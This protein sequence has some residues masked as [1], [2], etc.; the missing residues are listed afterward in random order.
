MATMREAL[1]GFYRQQQLPE[2]G[3]DGARLDW[4]TVFGLPVPIVNTDARMAVLPYHDMHHVLTGYGTDEQ[5]EALAGAWAIGAAGGPRIAR[6]YDLGT[7]GLGMLRWPGLTAAAFYRG[8]RGRQL[9]EHD[10]GELME[11]PVGAVAEL[12][13]TDLPPAR[14]TARDRLALA[15]ALALAGCV[16]LTPVA[17]MAQG[18]WLLADGLRGRRGPTG[19]AAVA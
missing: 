18:W 13:G 3:T 11:M 12:A 7:F 10:V 9:F 15:A 6:V 2:G 4:A 5:G 1:D 8:R 16:W 17:T 19:G 14:P